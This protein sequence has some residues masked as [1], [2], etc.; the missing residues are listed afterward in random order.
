MMAATS[1]NNFAP[2]PGGYGGMREDYRN[3]GQIPMPMMTGA[4]YGQV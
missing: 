1:S 4:P 2:M 3:Q